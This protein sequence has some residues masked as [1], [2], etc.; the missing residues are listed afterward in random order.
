M[1]TAKGLLA[2]TDGRAYKDTLPADVVYQGTLDTALENFNPG[3]DQAVLDAQ[4]ARTPLIVSY[5]SGAYR[6]ATGGATGR[7]ATLRPCTF[8]GPAS[9]PPAIDGVPNV[10]GGGMVPDGSL[11]NGL[12]DVF[13]AIG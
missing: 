9:N 10:Q 4:V 12:F 2:G 13:E 5:I 1:A 6:V 3:V 11:P 8:Q 7:P